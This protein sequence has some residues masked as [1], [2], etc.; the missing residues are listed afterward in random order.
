MLESWRTALRDMMRDHVQVPMTA[1]KESIMC[2]RWPAAFRNEVYHQIQA[3]I[4]YLLTWD[5]WM[6]W[7]IAAL[8]F[9][10]EHLWSCFIIS[11][12]IIFFG[13]WRIC[14]LSREQARQ[15]LIIH[16]I[17]DKPSSPER[18]EVIL[19]IC[20]EIKEG[21]EREGMLGLWRAEKLVE[22]PSVEKH[23]EQEN[24]GYVRVKRRVREECDK[25]DIN[26]P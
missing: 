22:I 6:K 25:F 16:R 4:S 8:Y 9:H 24:P 20:L 2:H 13:C 12:M 23:W 3:P 7:V 10:H 21:Y 11:L 18:D 26:I 19:D 15:C 14:V 1:V 5:T 17:M